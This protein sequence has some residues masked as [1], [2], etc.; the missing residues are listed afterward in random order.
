ML[1]E[2][3]GG[4]GNMDVL[5]AFSLKLCLKG[6]EGR[7]GEKERDRQ[8]SRFI[9]LESSNAEKFKAKIKN[10]PSGTERAL[11]PS[12]HGSHLALPALTVRPWPGDD[13]SWASVSPPVKWGQHQPILLPP[14][15]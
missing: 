8:I 6:E 5:K 12:D 7:E 11:W 15:L 3:D 2:E 10:H 13:P 14:P 9:V 4:C 1:G